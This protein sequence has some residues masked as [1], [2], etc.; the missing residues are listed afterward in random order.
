[1]ERLRLAFP[2]DVRKEEARYGNPSDQEETPVGKRVPLILAVP[3]SPARPAH[4]L[5]LDWLNK[6]W[7]RR[8]SLPV[9]PDTDQ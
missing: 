3:A 4:Y 5:E 1:M 9:N 7:I 6:T 8:A 2:D